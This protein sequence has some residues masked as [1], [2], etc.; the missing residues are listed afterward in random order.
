[1][2]YYCFNFEVAQNNRQCLITLESYVDI[3]VMK[4]KNVEICGTKQQPWIIETTK[5]QTISV[6]IT[7]P[8]S[9]DDIK[10]SLKGKINCPYDEI[11][12]YILDKSINRNVTI[13]SH[14]GESYQYI[15]TS[16]M[17]EVVF[18]HK[19]EG[20]PLFLKLRGNK[21]KKLILIITYELLYILL[22]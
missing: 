5:G 9:D 4:Q 2:F 18:L 22:I 21:V 8:T 20:S 7:T 17:I 10:T 13:C 16:N 1:M 3:H 19:T 14:V 11:E 12:G 15:S 6:G